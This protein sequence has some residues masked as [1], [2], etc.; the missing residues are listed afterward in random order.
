LLPLLLL[1][2]LLLVLE[3]QIALPAMGKDRVVV[4]RGR[5]SQHNR[6]R[7]GASQEEPGL[8]QIEKDSLK[9]TNST[10]STSSTSKQGS[11]APQGKRSSPEQQVGHQVHR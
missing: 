1:P 11:H 10:N 9:S 3:V 8:V 5:W 6:S 7:R 4:R 2:L